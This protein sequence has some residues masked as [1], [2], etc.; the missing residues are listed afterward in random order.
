MGEVLVHVHYTFK[1]PNPI[2]ISDL[3]TKGIWS[4]YALGM[5]YRKNTDTIQ[6]RGTVSW[7]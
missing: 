3:A 7:L 1:P 4:H 2:S 5:L 6:I